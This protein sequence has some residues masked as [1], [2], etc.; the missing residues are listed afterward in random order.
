VLI[1]VPSSETKRAASAVS[2]GLILDLRS[3]E[4][5]MF[6]RPTGQDHRMVTLRVHQGGDGRRIGDVIAKRVRG[7]AAHYLLESGAEPS[8]PDEL[9]TILG[10]R[11]PV[12]LSGSGRGR[13]SWTLTLMVDD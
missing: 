4:N 3:P 2:D 10:E 8:G 1:I 6:G 5:Q 7:E 12:E 13:G 9:A 11:W